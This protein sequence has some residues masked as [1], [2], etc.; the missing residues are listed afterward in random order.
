MGAL[1][2]LLYWVRLRSVAISRRWMEVGNED[3]GEE[4]EEDEDEK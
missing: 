3:E 4:E 2:C 1:S